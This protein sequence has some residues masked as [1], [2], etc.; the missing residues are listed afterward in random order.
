M[1]FNQ[2]VA[3]FEAKGTKPGERYFNAKAQEGPSGI[4][5]SP[6]GKDNYNP[7]KAEFKQKDPADTG[8]YDVAAVIGLLSK[9]LQLL[10]NDDVFED[11]MRGI[12]N[13]FKRNRH[14]ISA[15]QESVLKSKPKVIDNQWGEI[16]RLTKILNNPQ[17]DAITNTEKKKGGFTSTESPTTS[18]LSQDRA[19]FQA[20]LA[21]VKALKDEN[22][23]ILNAVYD[24]VDGVTERNEE[25]NNEY[26]E[27]LL[28]A[29]K[30]TTKRLYTKLSD[31]I[32]EGSDEPH[33]MKPITMHDLDWSMLEKRIT[34]DA[35]AQL[36]LLEMLGL[37][38]GKNPLIRFMEI[39][40]ENYNDA[41]DRYYQLRRG[42]NYS[43][44]T[45]QLYQNLPLFRFVNFLSNSIL[46]A[47]K[48]ALTTK[49]KKSVDGATSDGGGMFDRLGA[50]N[51]ERQFEELKPALIEYVDGL[52]LDEGQ[53]RAI[54]Q[55]ANGK[56]VV[57]RGAP[58]AAF[59]IRS[60]LKTAQITESFDDYAIK[61]LR[62]SQIN[63]DDYKLDMI[64][65]LS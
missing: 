15:Y 11:Q 24:D 59:K 37:E 57:R 36:Q 6:I 49:Q 1:N 53:K 19:Q 21:K 27:Q 50:I 30:H 56:F 12:M 34:K 47:P 20:D 64:E 8:G 33:K 17:Y 42:D 46:K 41:R 2:L 31:E 9:G 23:A 4:T 62:S 3:L 51:N 5:S 22:E 48:I 29:V 39:Q 45:D 32:R 10:K 28:T 65:V 61:I 35:E 43:V 18:R 58:N 44:T 55:L 13:G 38:D 25:L 52:D 16:N 60:L 14:Q 40:E 63:Y 54:K 26:L 7:E